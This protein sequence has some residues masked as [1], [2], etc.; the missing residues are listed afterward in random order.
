MEET[1]KPLYRM[2][3]GTQEDLNPKTQQRVQDLHERRNTEMQAKIQ[4]LDHNQRDELLQMVLT[5]LP[6][7]MF[8]ILD[9]LGEPDR[10]R[11][12]GGGDLLYI[13]APAQT[14]RK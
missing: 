4:A 8:D 10:Q 3:S 12:P 1:R 2:K 9:L 11:V 14:V 5:R 13:G 6:G 7:L